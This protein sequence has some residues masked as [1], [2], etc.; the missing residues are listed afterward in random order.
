MGMPDMRNWDEEAKQN[1]FNALKERDTL[2]G[3]DKENNDLAYVEKVMS[4]GHIYDEED[5][6]RDSQGL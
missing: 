6:S 5:L 3:W 1:A 4:D 2:F